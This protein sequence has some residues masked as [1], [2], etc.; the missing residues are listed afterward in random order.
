MRASEFQSRKLVIFDIDNTLVH[1]Q[2]KVRVIN[3]GKV[4]KEKSVNEAALYV[5]KCTVALVPILIEVWL[6]PK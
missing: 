6:V 5:P 1:T 2:T 3:D 4:V